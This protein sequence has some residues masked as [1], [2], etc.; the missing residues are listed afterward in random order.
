M[1]DTNVVIKVNGK[2]VDQYEHDNCTFIEAR[3]GT[4][5]TITVQNNSYNRKLAI[6]TVDGVNVITGEPQGNDNK[7]GYVIGSFD[8]VDIK[9][10][11]QDLNSVGTFK[12]CKSGESYC[13]QKGL[14]GNN[15]VIGVRIYREKL[16]D[17]VWTFTDSN[18]DNSYQ[19][20]PGNINYSDNTGSSIM[21]NV[22]RSN[23]TCSTVADKGCFDMGT[24]WG[25][26]L[27][28]SVTEVYFEP[29]VDFEETIIYYDTRKNLEK[30]GIS[31]K[32]EKKISMP[33]AFGNFAKPPK[34]WRG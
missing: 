1:K 14:R 16:N 32:K 19:K 33:K 12:F 17:I 18:S 23:I 7:N 5:Y 31:F 20:L 24:T 3:D 8:S 6:V 34:G 15:G 4:E 10:F 2:A 9:G 27:N 25:K 11:R 30:I 28:D 26:K 29:D 13:N 21:E 22:F